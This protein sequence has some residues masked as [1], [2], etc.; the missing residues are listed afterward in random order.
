MKIIEKDSSKVEDKLKAIE[1][2]FLREDSS[3]AIEMES[4][5]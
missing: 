4:E 2:K 1:N 3:S 5:R